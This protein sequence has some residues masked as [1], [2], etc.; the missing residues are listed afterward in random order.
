MAI[1]YL[2]YHYSIYYIYSANGLWLK[3]R[4][5]L[6]RNMKESKSL[7][8]GRFLKCPRCKQ[9]HSVEEYL[10]LREAEEFKTETSPVYK[11]PSCKWIFALAL[12]VPQEF[13]EQLSELL[14]TSKQRLSEKEPNSK[15]VA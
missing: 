7:L 12:Y 13:Y 15:Q 6:S 2:S 9:D 3:S 14:S 10:R 1:A 4:I 8:N 11:C 5:E